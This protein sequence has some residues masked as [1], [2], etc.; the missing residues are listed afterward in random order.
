M[1]LGRSSLLFIAVGSLFVVM[2]VARLL[3]RPSGSGEV[4]LDTTGLSAP[5]ASATSGVPM[6]GTPEPLRTP[7]LVIEATPTSGPITPVVVEVDGRTLDLSQSPIILLNPTAIRRGAAMGISGSGFDGDSIIDFVAKR[8]ASD[9]GEPLTFV[10][11]DQNGNFAGVSIT[12]PDT[13]AGTFIIEARQRAAD[14]QGYTKTA[15]AVG[16]VSGEATQVTLGTQVGKPGDT[17]S[18]SATG[19]D[20]DERIVVYWNILGQQQ[21]AELHSDASGNIDQ[22]TIRVPFGAAGN[23]VLILLGDKS[24]TPVTVPF[25]LLTLYPSVQL[26]N[27]AIKADEVLSFSGKDFGSGE[28]I[29]VYLNNPNTEPITIV[30]AESDGTFPQVSGFRVPFGMK[31]Q[32]TLIFIG[33]QSRAPTTASFDILPYTPNAQPSTYGGLP[34]TTISFYSF[35]FARQEIVRVYIERTSE[36]PGR[37]VSCY[38]TDEN[39]NATAAGTYVIGGDTPPGSLMF[40]LIGD[41]SAAETTATVEVMASNIPVQPSSQEDSFQC[42]LD[43]PPLTPPDTAPTVPSESGPGATPPS[44]APVPA[45]S[46]VPS[47]TPAASS[48]PTAE[49]TAEPIEPETSPSSPAEATPGAS[50]LITPTVQ[51]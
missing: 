29:D 2:V 12:V 21:V 35:G 50:D 32:Q 45:E 47:E 48:S 34:G 14:S 6:S 1:R 38:L 3:L 7:S 23:N 24:Q 31:G 42:P 41:K 33:E 37:L 19:F 46:P 10:Q 11:T 15:Q 8:D 26:S 39:G 27:Y 22:A 40:T 16:S 5:T 13:F 9:G 36:Q 28:A 18:L 49:P 20:S 44:S 43:Q 51:P 30:H 17:I 4:A 25:L